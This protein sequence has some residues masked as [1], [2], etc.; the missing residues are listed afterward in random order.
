M[1]E[2]SVGTKCYHKGSPVEIVCNEDGYIVAQYSNGVEIDSVK[3][4]DLSMT[5]VQPPARL[6]RNFD[7]PVKADD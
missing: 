3:V 7:Q 1:S 5:P 2:Y 6:R 4:A